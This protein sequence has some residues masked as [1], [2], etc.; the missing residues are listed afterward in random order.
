M[1]E[2]ADVGAGALGSRNS[3]EVVADSLTRHA[4]S[5]EGIVQDQRTIL[6]AGSVL[7]NENTSV[8]GRLLNSELLTWKAALDNNSCSCASTRYA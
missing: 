6:I 1:F 4:C 7:T 3:I 5:N 8:P 2:R